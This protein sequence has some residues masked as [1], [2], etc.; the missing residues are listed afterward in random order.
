MKDEAWQPPPGDTNPGAFGLEVHRRISA[1]LQGR[2]GWIIDVY[3]DDATNRIVSIG[4]PPAAGPTGTTQID[5]AGLEDGIRPKV[6][7]IW[8]Q[9]KAE[10]YEIKA[11]ASGRLVSGEQKVRLQALSRDSSIRC[12]RAPEVLKDGKWTVI[13]RVQQVVRVLG[14]VGLAASAW[15][16]IHHSKYDDEFDALKEKLARAASRTNDDDRFAEG[17]DLII[18]TKNYLSHFVPSETA[19]NLITLAAMYRLMDLYGKGFPAE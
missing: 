16:L 6:G 10:I 19:L 5:A 18:M 3:V 11:S 12:V 17:T 8:Q 9:N 15:S 13:A 1:K 4:K 7:D 2:D 14:M